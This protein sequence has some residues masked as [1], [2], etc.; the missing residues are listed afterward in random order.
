MWKISFRFN[1]GHS[2]DSISLKLDRTAVSIEKFLD[3][4]NPRRGEG[5]GGGLGFLELNKSI[6][7]L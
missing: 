5:G 3:Q 2:F 6:I 4:I 7:M 1:L